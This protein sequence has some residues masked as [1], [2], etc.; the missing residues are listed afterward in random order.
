MRSGDAIGQ[1]GRRASA[2][3]SE[4]REIQDVRRFL[5]RTTVAS[6]LL[7]GSRHPPTLA[8]PPFEASTAAGLNLADPDAAI[9]PH[10]LARGRRVARGMEVP[11][12]LGKFGAA[13]AQALALEFPGE[14]AQLVPKLLG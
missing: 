3:Y 11:E 9:E 1:S 2:H 10:E 14:R 4:P 8:T 13:R 7:E 6:G 12:R 5:M